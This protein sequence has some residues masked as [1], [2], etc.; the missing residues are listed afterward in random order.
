[1]GI[2]GDT[3]VENPLANAE[4]TRD[5]GSILGS[6]RSLGGGNGNLLQYSCLENSMDRGAWQATVHG[7][8]KSQ[9][10]LSTC[11]NINFNKYNIN[12]LVKCIIYIPFLSVDP[13]SFIVF[14]LLIQTPVSSQVLHLVVMYSLIWYISLALP[15]FKISTHL[16]NKICVLLSPF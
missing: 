4:D 9:A 5:E 11:T 10:W 14:L 7:V 15:V 3:V 8:T 6:E 13:V 12:I 2:L 16:K 1:V